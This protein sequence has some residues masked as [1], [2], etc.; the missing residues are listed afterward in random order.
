MSL[1][2]KKPY[3]TF[4]GV[5]LGLSSPVLLYTAD[6]FSL[7]I[8][9]YTFWSPIYLLGVLP[10]IVTDV[11]LTF[12][13]SLI[14]NSYSIAQLLFLIISQL[15]FAYLFASSTSNR[16]SN[17]TDIG[18]FRE[19]FDIPL[20]SYFVVLFRIYFILF[21]IYFIFSIFNT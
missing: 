6:I 18:S 9:V 17:F 4:W 12:F 13:S 5:F 8:P 15:L 1:G 19:K 21:W 14:E 2:M 7:T 3:F 20:R 10:A 16:G 11:V